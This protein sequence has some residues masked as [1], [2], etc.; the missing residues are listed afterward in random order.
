MIRLLSIRR[1]DW[2]N[3]AIIRDQDV[4]PKD[5]CLPVRT[6]NKIKITPESTSKNRETTQ[7]SEQPA[8]LDSS[9]QGRESRTHSTKMKHGKGKSKKRR[10]RFNVQRSTTISCETEMERKRKRNEM[11]TKWKQKRKGK[12]KENGLCT[13]VV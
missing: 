9:R 10:L 12:G 4:T 11:E 7:V 2:T 5:Q 13:M 6:V 3:G 1:G 8:I